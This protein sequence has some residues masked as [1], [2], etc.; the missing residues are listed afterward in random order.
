MSISATARV[1]GHS[2]NTIARWLE[3]ASTAAKR[4]NYVRLRDFDLIELQADEL[5]TFIGNKR[6]TVWLF[7]TIE[8]SSRLWAG[9]VLGRRSDRNAR[10]VINDVIRRGRVVGCPL[11]ATDGFEYYFGAVPAERVG[12]SR[13][14]VTPIRRR[15]GPDAR[16]P[17]AAVPGPRVSVAGVGRARL[18]DAPATG[19]PT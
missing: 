4:F 11:I 2:R 3:R 13:I 17:A 14:S 5:S 1:T 9:S 15:G 19:A 16:G 7:A 6:K 12:V 8:V 18:S 10:A